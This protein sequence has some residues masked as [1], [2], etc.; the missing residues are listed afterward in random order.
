M[1][2]IPPH[3]RQSKDS[4]RPSPIPES[5]RP[6]F[7]RN[8]DLRSS[9]SVK[10]RS[11]K[12]TYAKRAVSTWF[13]VGLDDDNHFPSSVQLEPVSMESIERRTGEKPLAL[14]N[15]NLGKVE[16]AQAGGDCVTKPWVSIADNVLPN[17][18]SSFEN[19]RNEAVRQKLENV[20]P[21]LVARFGNILFH[22]SPSI[23]QETTAIDL[24]AETTLR[25]LKR[26]FYTNLPNSD[27]EKIKGEVAGKI[28]VDFDEEKDLYHVKLSDATQ[29][30]STL[31]CKCRVMKEHKKLQLYKVELN[32]V[33]HMVVDISCLDKSLDLRLMLYNKGVLTSLT[34]DE[35]E[36]IRN[37]INSAVL[38]PDVKGGLRW[39]LGYAS[40][41]N[42]Y[43]V[44]GVW[45]TIAKAYKSPST[46]LKVREADR[47][48]FKTSTGE[49][50]R[51]I[52]LKVKSVI[53][54]LQEQAVEITSV[55]EMLKDTLR[56]IWNLIP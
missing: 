42:R 26:T 32:P 29:P 15:R 16:D 5:F 40:S 18:L 55:S 10:D 33:R 20:K 8:L 1:S 31:S 43:C 25:T 24:A 50:S 41:G 23:N 19:V 14:A 37:L 2:Y 4:D 53:S 56:L 44:V 11:G 13:A 30:D 3:K 12:I 49:A 38:D 27:I 22:G 6:N 21:T 7:R 35:L 51:E 46:R 54:L 52:N 34:D 28:E 47:F 39:P 36:N 48:D 17:L 45:H 9:K